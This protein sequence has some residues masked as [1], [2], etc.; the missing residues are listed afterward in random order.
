MSGPA[1]RLTL[2]RDVDALPEDLVRDPLTFL[3]AEHWRHRQFCRALSEVAGLSA[4][5]PRLLR[6]LATFLR[7]DMGLHVEDEE[8]DLFRLLRAHAEPE[9]DLDRVLGILSADHDTDRALALAI[10]AG[11]EQAAQACTG[12]AAVDGLPDTISRFVTHQMRHLAL[13]NAVVLPI[14]R[15]RLDADACAE[16]ASA[17]QARRA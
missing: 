7:E 12:P 3:F 1:P 2:V 13:E 6:K 16:L 4:V 9:D 15:L 10:V 11:L 8:Q 17:L 5:A 14:A